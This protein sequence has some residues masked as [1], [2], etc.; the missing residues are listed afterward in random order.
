[1]LV[2]FVPTHCFF[3]NT[4]WPHLRCDAISSVA[5]KC[6]FFLPGTC[7]NAKLISPENTFESKVKN[8]LNNLIIILAGPN[9]CC[10][11]DQQTNHFIFWSNHLNEKKNILVVNGDE[12]PFNE[13]I[14]KISRNQGFLV[15]RNFQWILDSR[16]WTL[17]THAI[18]HRQEKKRRKKHRDERWQNIKRIFFSNEKN[19][20]EKHVIYVKRV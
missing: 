3:V 10:Y 13:T 14:H 18:A 12:C 11:Q 6:E 2:N 5:T 9:F 17:C 20:F 16:T 15:T 7:F 4:S 19:S 1:M 8:H